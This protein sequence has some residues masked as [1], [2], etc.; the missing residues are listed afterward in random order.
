MSDFDRMET[1]FR[2]SLMAQRETSLELRA[3]SEKVT[4]LSEVMSQGL[5]EVASGLTGLAE[6]TDGLSERLED[7]IGVMRSFAE[8]QA[9]LRKTV[10]DCVRR[11]DRIEGK[12]AS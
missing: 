8:D 6:K 10:Q 11:L 4:K 9:E 2:L 1:N 5:S 7:S 12:E 3:L